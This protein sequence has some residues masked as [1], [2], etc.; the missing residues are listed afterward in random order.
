MGWKFG[1]SAMVKEL[2]FVDYLCVSCL[3]LLNTGPQTSREK[4]SYKV[5]FVLR[6]D[7][8]SLVASILQRDRCAR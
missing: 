8:D 7:N 2:I 6:Y 4:E 1:L 3:A 5:S